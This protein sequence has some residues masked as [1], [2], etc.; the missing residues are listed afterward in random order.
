VDEPASVERLRGEIE[1]LRASRAR[2]AATADGERR[3]IERALH[4]GVQQDL[5]AVAVNLQLARELADSE[6]ASSYLEAASRDVHDALAEAL[7]GAA[8]TARVPTSVDAPEDR[9]PPEIEAAVYFTCVRILDAVEAG[10]ARVRIWPEGGSLLFEVVVEGGWAP[11]SAELED[12][13]GAAG[14]SLSFFPAGVRGTIPL[15]R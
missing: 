14:G 6:D 11:E 4:D 8:R 15:P 10:R 13:A 7:R 3:K 1:E 9:Y 2:I 12:P 5:I